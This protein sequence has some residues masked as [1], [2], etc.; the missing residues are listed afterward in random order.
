VLRTQETATEERLTCA[1]DQAE[2]EEGKSQHTDAE[3]QQPGSSEVSA[4]ALS[5]GLGPLCPA[6]PAELTD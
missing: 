3:S 1:R 5:P 4:A 2:M 6:E